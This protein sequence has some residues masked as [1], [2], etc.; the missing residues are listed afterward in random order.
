MRR[1]RPLPGAPRTQRVGGRSG[2]KDAT[3]G[4]FLLPG[5]ALAGEEGAFLFLLCSRRRDKGGAGELRSPARG[6]H[7]RR[8]RCPAAPGPAPPRTS[9]R[10]A[11]RGRR[12]QG[13][14]RGLPRAP[15]ASLLLLTWHL[16]TM[17]ASCASRSTTLPLPSSPHWAPSTTVTL[18]PGRRAAHSPLGMPGPPCS[19]MARAAR[20]GAAPGTCSSAR[21]PLRSPRL[22]LLLPLPAGRAGG[23]AALA[24]RCHRLSA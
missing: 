7:Q 19:A 10:C 23:A 24:S 8:L 2:R 15:A 16:Q 21:Q 22:R 20:S 13:D 1:A 12:P 4:A 3:P 11:R 5:P 6:S 17:S 14:T 18:L 9:V